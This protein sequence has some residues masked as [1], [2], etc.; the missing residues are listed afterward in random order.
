MPIEQLAIGSLLSCPIAQ[1]QRRELGFVDNSVR[2]TSVK[3]FPAAPVRQLVTE[4]HERRCGIYRADFRATIDPCNRI[5]ENRVEQS[6]VG[7]SVLANHVA[8]Q[9]LEKGDL[10]L[11]G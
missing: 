4:V 1:L 9:I 11:A 3:P 6:G 5:A 2:Y 7:V 8:R 10:V